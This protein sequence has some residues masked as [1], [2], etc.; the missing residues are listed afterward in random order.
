MKFDEWLR[1]GIA[2]GWCGPAVCYTHDGLPMS[3][4]EADDEDM[5]VHVI[6]LYADEETKQKVE[7][8]HSPSNWR[9]P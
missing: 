8:F 5:C 7:Y 9:K 1:T 4:E 6:R 3:E 2:Q